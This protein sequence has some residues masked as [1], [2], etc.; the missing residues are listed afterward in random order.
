M[1]TMVY[2]YED[3]KFCVDCASILLDENGRALTSDTSNATSEPVAYPVECD[4]CG[5]RI[6]PTL[7]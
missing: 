4:E 7:T 5:I 6:V 1:A 3:E 2:F